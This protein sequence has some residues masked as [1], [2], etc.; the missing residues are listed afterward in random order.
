M[1]P[2][3]ALG[4]CKVPALWF[5][6]WLCDLEHVDTAPWPQAPLSIVLRGAHTS[7]WSP[8]K[9]KAQCPFLPGRPGAVP[10]QREAPRRRGVCIVSH[11][12]LWR[13]L[14][15]GEFL[16]PAL[17]RPQCQGTPFEKLRLTWTSQKCSC[18]RQAVR[19]QSFRGKHRS[20]PPFTSSLCREIWAM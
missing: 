8:G 17:P 12:L 3:E 14:L 6:K 4:Q 9:N 7:G 20:R 2:R 15:K 5:R 19:G 10:V 1:G 16:I 13:T 11:S 18:F